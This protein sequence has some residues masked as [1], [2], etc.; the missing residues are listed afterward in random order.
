MNAIKTG[1]WTVIFILDIVSAVNSSAR[2]TSIIGL[3][4][5]VVL[6]YVLH[7][8]G[9]IFLAFFLTCHSLSFWIPLIYGSVIYH[10]SR[11]TARYKPVEH[12]LSMPQSNIAPTEYPSQYKKFVTEEHHDDVESAPG[13]PRRLS[14]NHQRDTRFESYRQERTS[15]SDPGAV[16][17]AMGSPP[18][19]SPPIPEVYVQHHDGDAFEMESTRRDVR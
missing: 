16:E 1:I 5:D 6:L 15:F 14:Y 18:M 2:T 3:L 10:R 13:R 8:R 11:R 7:F 17:R 19:G 4:I 12:P 9:I